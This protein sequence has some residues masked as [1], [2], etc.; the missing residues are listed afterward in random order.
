MPALIA[1]L[2][3]VLVGLLLSNWLMR[4]FGH[5]QNLSGRISAYMT[6]SRRERAEG[7]RSA[8]GWRGIWQS[9][10]KLAPKR[11]SQ[12]YS[13]I[14]QQ[15]SLPIKGEE[16]AGAIGLAAICGVAL[17]G[18]LLSVPGWFLGGLLGGKLP[19]YLLKA[20]L[21]HRLRMAEQQFVD[22][23]TLCANAM[24][25]GHSWLQALELA[26]R[27][28][29]APMGPELG[30]T[31]REVSLG[32]PVEEALLRMVERL[33]SAD[34]DL[35]ITAVLIQRQV[36]GD[37]ASILDNIAATIRERQRIKAEVRTITA[38]GRLSGWVISLLPAVLAL[39]L[40]AM[41]PEY[42]SLLWTHPLGVMMLGFSLV[43]M[44]LG[45]F[46]INK[47]VKIDV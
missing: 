2:A 42:I 32:L 19:G 5:Q 46:A 11:L 16:M 22:F 29:P 9:V 23:L 35:M 37:L 20:H 43:S 18:L 27:E 44:G 33:P 14:L 21:R 25:A 3:A 17:G 1:A 41:N 26:A 47:I 34:L 39:V 40:N 24:R 12:H 4:K 15:A 31:L 7:V 38:Q 45:V 28:M 30:R 8:P 13:H 10:G 6:P 36:G